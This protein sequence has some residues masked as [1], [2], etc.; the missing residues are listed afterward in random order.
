[1]GSTYTEI[2]LGSSN[3]AQMVSSD[4][5]A[6][7]MKHVCAF[8]S[9]SVTNTRDVIIYDVPHSC[10][11]SSYPDFVYELI[12][13]SSESKVCF[14]AVQVVSTETVF[15]TYPAYQ[16]EFDRLTIKR[17]HKSEAGFLMLEDSRYRS[18]TFVK[19]R[20]TVRLA[21]PY[22]SAAVI[23]EELYLCPYTTQNSSLIFKCSPTYSIR[24]ISPGHISNSKTLSLVNSI[25]PRPVSGTYESNTRSKR[26]TVV[27]SSF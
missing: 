23:F 19:N 16:S 5:Y 21:R 15:Q 1:M 25:F 14:N 10:V 17:G 27:N 12:V 3:H 26:R 4:I 6:K 8:Y 13:L 7:C 18:V 24:L 11:E 22:T 2:S 9:E 20:K